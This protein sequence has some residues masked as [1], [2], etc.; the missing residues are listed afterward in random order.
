M[1]GVRYDILESS[2][3]TLLTDSGV[4]RRAL[5]AKPDSKP[6]PLAVLQGELADIEQQ[7]AKFMKL[8]KGDPNPSRAVYA[9]L[10][11]AEAKADDLR[12]RI[13]EETAKKWNTVT[14][15][16]VWEKAYKL[17]VGGI[18]PLTPYCNHP[19]GQALL[20]RANAL[21]ERVRTL[22][23]PAVLKPENRA[24]LREMIREVVDRVV[25]HLGCDRYEVY[26]KGSQQP[27]EVVLDK[28]NSGWGF[29]PAP[30]WVTDP[31]SYQQ[32]AATGEFTNVLG[33]VGVA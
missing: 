9:A 5:A 20:G 16:E 28:K 6:S 30:L 27:I 2:F 4:I 11:E 26:L 23:Q 13:E 1:T 22:A 32:K 31:S 33:A 7:S 8:I 12:A 25:A 10:K 21:I 19:D 29:S 18:E 15:L 17:L 14:P 24:Q 3:L